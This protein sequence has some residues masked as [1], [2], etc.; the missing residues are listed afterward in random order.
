MWLKGGTI[1][2]YAAGSALGALLFMR[3]QYLGF[4]MPASLSFYA[5]LLALPSQRAARKFFEV[6]QRIPRH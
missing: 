3:I 6:L 2:S 1:A 4:L 5:M